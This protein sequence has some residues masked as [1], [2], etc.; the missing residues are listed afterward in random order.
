VKDGGEKRVKEVK[1][2]KIRP[3]SDN[4]AVKEAAVPGERRRNKG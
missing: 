1:T 4:P 2:V 3:K